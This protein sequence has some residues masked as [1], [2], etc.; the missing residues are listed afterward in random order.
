MPALRELGRILLQ[1]RVHRLDCRVALEWAPARAHLVEHGAEREDV[2][3]R[4][5]RVAAELLGRH[6]TDGPEDGAGLGGLRGGRGMRVVGGRQRE[7]PRQAEVEDLDAPVGGHEEV[8]GFQVPMDDSP[9]V[10]RCESEGD[11]P[12]DLE[13]LALRKRAFLETLSKRL[14]LEQLHDCVG[15][16]VGG[17]DVVDRQ[18]VRMREGGDRLRLP[19]EARERRGVAGDALGKD[20]D[21]D[22]P[23]EPRVPRPVDLA[24]PARAERRQDLVGAE[25]CPGWECHRMTVSDSMPPGRA[26]RIGRGERI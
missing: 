7:L 24:H 25:T 1:D 23:V 4:I 14:P 22:V 2:A 13:R 21:R 16:A 18:D 11:L 9:L 15:D 19:L 12:R 3:P 26:K 10:R 8:L 6:V 17:A 5:G 20:L